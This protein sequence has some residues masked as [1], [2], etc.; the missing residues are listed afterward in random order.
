MW[1]RSYIGHDVSTLVA[2]VGCQQTY[3]DAFDVGVIVGGHRRGD[4]S[5]KTQE[6]GKSWKTHVVKIWP[7]WGA[8]QGK[9]G[10]GMDGVAVSPGPEN[11]GEIVNRR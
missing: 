6:G 4:Q 11:P 8:A 1:V 10:G 3:R 2:S 9:T 5:C 7:N